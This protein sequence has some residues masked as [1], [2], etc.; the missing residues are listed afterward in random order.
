MFAYIKRITMPYKPFKKV[1][2]FF[3]IFLLCLS[4]VFAQSGGWQYLINYGLW[5]ET[6]FEDV[7]FT[8]TSTGYAVEIRDY[9]LDS[10][11]KPIYKTIDGG[12]SWTNVGPSYYGS[13]ALRSIEF[14]DDKATGMVGSLFG[15]VYRTTNAGATWTD[16]SKSVA[17]TVAD[18]LPYGRRN[19]CGIAHFGNNFYAVGWW[20]AS[21]ARFYKST[22]K[23]VTWSTTYIDTNLATCLIDAAFLSTDTGF[24]TGGKNIFGGSFYASSDE[25]VILKTTDGGATWTKVFSD[26]TI[27]GR[28]WKIQLLDKM[29][30]VASIEPY[31]YPD[32]VNMIKSTDGGNT[33]TIINV[34][35][36]KDLA[37][38]SMC[39]MTQG[40]GFA[41][42]KTGWLGGYYNGIF[43]TVDGGK[44]WDTLHFGTCFNRIFVIDSTHVFA[45]GQYIYKWSPV[46]DTSTVVA[47]QTIKPPHI[48]YPISPNPAMGT[49]KIEFDILNETNVLLQ[50]VNVTERKH[51]T[52]TQG[53]F[54]PGHY[55]YYWNSNNMPP[56]D[57]LVWLGTN[58]IP[59]VQKFVLEK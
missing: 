16:I 31:Y 51:T 50:V 7:Y 44:T 25:S 26:T 23:G 39:C 4:N 29:N 54:K 32:S 41:T 20:G 2:L 13:V 11:Q 17:D 53:R 19:I 3:P 24:V 43:Q 30:I 58:E 49:V 40:V 35:S 28:I 48:L 37:Y 12:Y 42:T 22:D 56:G 27:G 46:S 1:L 47:N 57:Y 15:T 10:L 52:I 6:R 18:T 45:G 38:G 34:G 5:V 9:S 55:T 14:L 21:I 59:L 36:I 8:D 33:W